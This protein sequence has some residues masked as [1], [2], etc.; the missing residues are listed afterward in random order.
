MN[1]P[2]ISA[3]IITYNEENNIKDCLES[4]KWLD[5]IIVI[6]SFSN[7]KTVEICQQYTDKIYQR[8]WPGHIEQKNFA[9]EKASYDWILAID[10]D[11]R[12]SPPLVEEI[13]REFN[14][15][16]NSIDG[17]YFPR[18]SYYLG[19]WINNGGWYPD[20]KLRLFRKK[21]AR[22]GGKNPHDQVIMKGSTKYLKEDLWHYVYRDLSHQL[23]TVDNYSHITA[24]IMQKDGKSFSLIKLLFRPPIKFIETYIIK[25][26]FKDGFPGLIISI[27]SSFYVFLKYAKLWEIKQELK[28]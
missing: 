3:C 12:L 19:R 16:D 9:V 18:H 11:E 27:V 5:E 2:K 4:V 26:G 14:I 1:E 23:K 21:N 6:D 20:Y 22:W 10:A 15:V 28:R 8:T 7:D 17:Y 25:K 13:K 24:K